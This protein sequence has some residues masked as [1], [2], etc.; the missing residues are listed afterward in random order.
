MTR[1]FGTVLMSP[2]NCFSANPPSKVGFFL[3]IRIRLCTLIIV[4]D[5]SLFKIYFRD[6]KKDGR[7]GG[8]KVREKDFVFHL[9]M[10]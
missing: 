8:E 7:E 5:S 2:L 10:H 6:R 4:K 3:H 1:Q 9:F